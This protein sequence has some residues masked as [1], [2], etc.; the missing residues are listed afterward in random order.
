MAL[1]FCDSFAQ[2]GDSEHAEGDGEFAG[3]FWTAQEGHWTCES[4]ED[5]RSKI[6][7]SSGSLDPSYLS[8]S[9]GGSYS[10]LVVGIRIYYEQSESDPN[11]DLLR[12]FDGPYH[13]GGIFIDTTTGILRYCKSSQ[14]TNPVAYSSTGTSL[15]SSD[16]WEIKIVFHN[17]A[18]SV[19]FYK[20]GVLDNETTG[21]DTI[22]DSSASECDS[23]W[24][25]QGSNADHGEYKFSDF[26]VD[27]ATLHGDV[28]VTYEPCDTAGSESDWTPAA[29]TNESQVDEYE[30]D[31]DT[32]YNSSSTATDKDS[33][34]CGAATDLNDVK[35]VMA[36]ACARK[37]DANSGAIKLGVLHSGTEEQS[38]ALDL[39][40]N[41]EW[42][43]Y[44]RE[45][46]PGGT[47]WTELQLEAAEISIENVSA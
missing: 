4:I 7:L 21:I 40:T 15:G 30:V 33:L 9:L 12:F 41:Y 42:R 1:I 46:V 16:Y 3:S 24:L 38:D 25:M 6:Y 18:G 20:N 13:L 17:S 14:Y 31:G 26:Y 2:Y 23:M 44:V 39:N 34:E 29:S 47:G 5:G 8:G 22:Y 32:T 28:Y 37:E 36:I 27:S 19:A 10:T 35:A 11:L 43:H 45:D